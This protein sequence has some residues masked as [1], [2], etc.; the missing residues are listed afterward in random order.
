MAALSNAITSY[1]SI[2]TK[3][4]LFG[5]E[6]DLHQKPFKT[7]YQD[8]HS[9]TFIYYRKYSH[10]PMGHWQCD[11]KEPSP[12][13]QYR[14]KYIYAGDSSEHDRIKANLKE[15]GVNEFFVEAEDDSNEMEHWNYIFVSAQ[16]YANI[17]N[18]MKNIRI[19]DQPSV[20]NLEK[21]LKEK[22]PPS[23]AII[24]IVNSP[25]PKSWFEK[26]MEITKN[27]FETKIENKGKTFE[28]AWNVPTGKDL[29]LKLAEFHGLLK[30]NN[31]L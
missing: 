14:V 9:I 15:I 27:E 25:F 31:N 6:W 2:E 11:S 10:H 5:Y 17:S 29:I 21:A 20:E 28:P 30:K 1:E 16:N 3:N 4:K 18:A 13:L 7:G 23:N 19:I 12:S 26:Y 24:Y 8:Q 22:L